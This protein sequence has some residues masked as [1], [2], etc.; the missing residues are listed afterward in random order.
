MAESQ[1]DIYV[2]KD[3]FDARMDRMEMLLE[4][5]VLEIKAY[6]DK[7]IS[8]TKSYVEKSV[9]EIKAEL[10]QNGNDIKALTVRV[11]ALEQTLGARISAVENTLYWWIGLF[12][13]FIA[14]TAFFAPILA[15][16]K[17]MFKPS[18][19]I[20]DVERIVNTAIATHLSGGKTE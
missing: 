17:K 18:V 20:E 14:I 10:R 4:K 15:F 7:S 13:I 5:T 3:V 2:R 1:G 8:E 16:F 19:T 11:D 9:D 6:V 12:A